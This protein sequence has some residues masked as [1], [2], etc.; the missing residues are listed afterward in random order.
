MEEAL[1]RAAATSGFVD[2]AGF[3][4]FAQLLQKLEPARLL[5][6]AVASDLSLQ[7]LVRACAVRAGQGPF[8]TWALTP[9]FARAAATLF[10]ELKGGGLEP[11][12][13]RR[14]VRAFPESSRERGAWLAR[15]WWA[16]EQA[17]RARGLADAGDV[18]L[19]ATR[20]LR[21]EGLPPALARFGGVSF[22]ALHD[23]PPARRALLLA[24]ASACERAGVAFRLELPAAGGPGAD[25]A[26]DPVL[27]LFEAEAQAWTHVEAL[28]DDRAPES[29][30]GAIGAVLFTADPRTAEIPPG[31][32]R[33][34]RAASERAELGAIVREVA[35]A[36]EAGLPP[37]EVAVAFPA[38]GDEA[39][40]LR[41]HLAE[42]DIPAWTRRGS[43]LADTPLG[44]HALS[45]PGLV[46]EN[47]PA[48]RVA[49]LLAGHHAPALGPPL[50]SAFRLLADAAVTDDVVGATGGV[51]AF[52]LRLG[53]LAVRRER[54]GREREAARARALLE[55]C[56]AVLALREHLPP[57]ASAAAFVAGWWRAVEALGMDRCAR[58]QQEIPG[59]EGRLGR[60]RAE[61]LARDEAAF[62]ALAELAA[63]LN[64]A[65]SA[66]GA[67][68]AELERPEFIRWLEAAAAQVRLEPRGL[69]TGAVQVLDLREIPGRSFRRLFLAGLSGARFPARE[70]PPVLLGEDAL[71]ALNRRERREVV[72]LRS[73]EEEGRAPWALAE[74]RLLFACA[75]SAAPECILSW[76]ASVGG[77][78]QLPS[79]VLEELLRRTNLGVESLPSAPVPRLSEAIHEED[80]RARLAL[81]FLSPPSLRVGEADPAA[82]AAALAEASAPWMGEARELSQVEVERL[83]HFAS[84]DAPPGPFT[85]WV[86]G[87][88]EAL[89]FGPERPLSA[90]TLQRAANCRFQ[91]FLSDVLGLDGADAP[92]EDLDAA[93]RGNLWH[94][95]LEAL[96]P[97]LAEAGLLGRA[98]ADVPAA[99]LEAA[100]ARA[101]ARVKARNHVGHP[102][103]FQLA[104]ERA[105]SMARRLL[106]ASHAGLPFDGLV[107]SG[108][109]VAFGVPEARPELREVQ[110]PAALPGEAPVHFRGGMDRLDEAGGRL[111]VVDYKSG[112]VRRRPEDL[113]VSE[114]QLPLYVYAA[115][116]WA[117]EAAV[118]GAWLSLKDG[119]APTLSSLFEGGVPPSFFAVDEPSRARASEEGVPNFANAVHAHVGALRRGDFAVHPR[120][121]GHCSFRPICRF[122][123][124]DA[125]EESAE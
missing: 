100:V 17:L 28:K 8:G 122:R 110:L 12:S 22:H 33:V 47:F 124:D 104:Q 29:G 40:V 56:R 45:L 65:L 71:A 25:A 84:A 99:L 19:A 118:D 76:P 18:L 58:G 7:W 23:F 5:G 37:E 83:R 75:L 1:V 105:S 92:G 34:L 67:G 91:A 95:V 106:D 69:R 55:R 102:A 63:A 27:Q 59:P 72:R 30:L 10:S 73:G 94:A 107:P 79:P 2:A 89:A 123:S 90:A 62:R 119:E 14:A 120:D 51:G 6:R 64:A 121:C 16:Y 114:F 97:A 32:L 80:R 116:Q 53:G 15:T 43:P 3:C 101:V 61:A 52:E 31:R 98:A 21:T 66:S 112:T 35:Q 88:G 24:L 38:L 26:V 117:P 54:Q 57:R 4:T 78:E 44:R 125:G 68:G 85:G 93:A 70:R 36:L 109:E 87:A 108:H 11:L 82:R 81:E 20:R 39:E 48:E 41:A 9:A 77:R 113:L 103:L 49:H 46:E 50:P 115:R 13:F 42:L 111:A 86:P 74:Q 60:A 96:F